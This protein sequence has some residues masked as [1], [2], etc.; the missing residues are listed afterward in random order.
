MTGPGSGRNFGCMNPIALIEA[1][2]ATRSAM[3]GAMADPLISP[4]DFPATDVAAFLRSL[5]AR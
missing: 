1:G 2:A 5:R 4:R 3:L